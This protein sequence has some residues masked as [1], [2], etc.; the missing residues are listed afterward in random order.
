MRLIK[1]SLWN[2]GG[3]IIPA[4]VTIPSLGVMGRVL[5]AELFGVFTLALA[6]VGYA[7]IFD[8][9][10]TRAVIR[11]IAIERNNENNKL[12]IISSATVVILALSLMAAILLFL[13]SDQVTTLLKIDVVL[14]EQVSYSFRI[15]SFSIPF[16]LITQ[17]WLSILEGEEKFAILN[18]YK[19]ITGT[20][21]SLLP[22]AFILYKPKLEYAI[23]GLVTARLLCLM[24]AFY[25]CSKDILKAKL[26]ID[27]K[28]IKR[29][30]MFG[31]WITV[32]N[33]ISPI[34]SYFDRF[35]V[36]NQLGAA[37]VA[38]Y[39][40]PSEIIARLSIVP[41]A[42]ARALFPRLSHTT[43]PEEQAKTKRLITLI[44]FAIS[45][46]T[47]LIGAIFSEKIMIIWMGPSFLGTSGNVLA[48]L[49]V[50][51]L[52][53]SLAQVPFASIQSRGFAKITAFVHLME[54]VPY[55]LLLF[56]LI[57]QH[58]LIGAATAWSVRMFVDFV[59]LILLD[60]NITR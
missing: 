54:L 21:L 51:F 2:I 28:T 24:I 40:A 41:G 38:F 13:G 29:L 42:F 59:I 36:S 5:G 15:L 47:L 12:K 48:I 57:K 20:L 17:I 3:Y 8:A 56:Y 55:L 11:E 35:I 6:V 23:A 53:N 34:L 43:H 60:K 52:F 1:N 27:R 46:P 7:S 31:G 50:G 44:L 19:T 30:F 39:T 22:V 49:L 16:F 45:F 25:L 9:G 10:L 32:S 58:G 33:I 14:H 37:N 4:I 18:V 26:S